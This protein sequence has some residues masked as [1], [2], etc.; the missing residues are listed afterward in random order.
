MV[1]HGPNYSYTESRTL[2]LACVT[3][4][5]R[6]LIIVIFKTELA[7]RAAFASPVEHILKTVKSEQVQVFLLLTNC[8]IMFLIDDGL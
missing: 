4:P 6:F 1:K 5:I 8:N 3:R 7:S 2:S